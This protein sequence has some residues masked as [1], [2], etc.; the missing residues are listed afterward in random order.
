VK[1]RELIGYGCFLQ[2]V[3]HHSWDV[4]QMPVKAKSCAL[5][6][7]TLA[8]QQSSCLPHLRQFKFCCVNNMDA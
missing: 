1:W 8:S 4:C 3:E 6:V 7:G 2:V 5:F